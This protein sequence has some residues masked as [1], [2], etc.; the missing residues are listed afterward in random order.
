[1]EARFRENADHKKTADLEE[2]LQKYIDLINFAP[3][4]LAVI[5]QKGQIIEA[6]QTLSHLLGLEKDCLAGKSWFSSLLD[7]DQDPALKHLSEVVKTK[8]T[9]S[10]K[11]GN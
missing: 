8:K 1:M 9:L 5:D 11:K 2:S 3:I 10:P 7:E 6:N 4:G